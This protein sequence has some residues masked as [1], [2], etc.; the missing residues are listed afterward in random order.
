MSKQIKDGWV[1]TQEPD[2]EGKTVVT[3]AREQVEG[4]PVVLRIY[5]FAHY[6]DQDPLDILYGVAPELFEET[7]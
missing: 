4:E 6:P 5:N 2:E 7:A 1:V 3:V